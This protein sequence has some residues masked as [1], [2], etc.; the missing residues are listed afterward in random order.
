MGG[1][2]TL[3]AQLLFRR[4]FQADMVGRGWNDADILMEE[5]HM[6]IS[7]PPFWKIALPLVRR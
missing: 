5:A 4:N 7:A 6:I 3:S 1:E 2:F